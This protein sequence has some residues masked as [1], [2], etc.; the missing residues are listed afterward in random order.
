MFQDSRKKMGAARGV[1]P[2][3]IALAAVVVTAAPAA[4]QEYC[5]GGETTSLCGYVW[6]DTNN[7]G[8]QDAGETPVEGAVVTLYDIT[9]P[10]TP[11]EVG[12][13]ATD[14][15]GLYSFDDV[16]TGS[17]YSVSVLSSS[18]A[19]G[20]QPSPADNPAAPDDTVDSDGTLD[21]PSSVVTIANYD[22]TKLAF[23][24]GFSTSTV[25]VSPGTGTP[26]YWKNHPE[27]WPDGVTVGGVYY[28]T[29]DAIALMGKVSKDKTITIFSSLLAA[30]LN[31]AIGNA[32]FCIA[33]TIEDANEWLGLHA[34]GSGVAA[35]SAAWA[36]ASPL[37][38]LL[39]EYNNGLSCAPHRN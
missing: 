28:T 17:T 38:K 12:S 4:A 21:G 32:D 2:F 19:T 37:H 22:G 27:V 9:N 7:D 5:P 20:A 1:I 14:S 25:G 10:M 13:T 6:N 15:N 24:F 26:G 16:P 30:T 35:S 23:D 39:D 18:I 34:P 33:E 11:V 29:A 36:V 3:A 31:V 8:I